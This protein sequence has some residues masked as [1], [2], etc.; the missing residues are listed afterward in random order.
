MITAAADGSALGNPGPSGWAWFVDDDHWRCGGWP[1]GTNNI[2][3]LTAVLDLLQCTAGSGE[4]L[5]VYCDSQYVINSIT[6]WMAGWKRKGWKRADGKPVQNQALMQSLDQAM[7]QTRAE[8][9]SVRFEWVK[10]HAGHELN[11]RA[12]QLARGA[13]TAHQRGEP[14]AAGPGFG[15]DTPAE[16]RAAHPSVVE[17]EPDQQPGLFEQADS[18][19][20]TS[21][22]SSRITIE[23]GRADQA[24]LELLADRLGTDP[25]Q[26]LLHLLRSAR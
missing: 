11:E 21:T 23:L 18:T 1:M 3:E 2:G 6:K 16:P 17:A 25:A 5:L 20:V 13:A 8:G 4:D 26:A 14:C 10:G 12:D 22:R 7:A 9:R 19:P 24:R 15:Q